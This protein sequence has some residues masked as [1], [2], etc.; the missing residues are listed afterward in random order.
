MAPI[1]D[2]LKKGEF[3]WSHITRKAFV[4][5][6]KRMVSAPVMRLSDFSEVFEMV[7]DAS[8]IGIGRVLTQ[9]GHPVAYFSKKLNDA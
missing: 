1:T 9:E 6:K 7:C 2:Y 3:H 4:E 8:G 5:I